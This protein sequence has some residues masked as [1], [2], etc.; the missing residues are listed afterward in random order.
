MQFKWGKWRGHRKIIYGSMR[1]KG[2][3][4]RI[5]ITYFIKSDHKN[6]SRP[7]PGDPNPCQN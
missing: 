2:P 4:P 1:V 3:R 6:G 5:Q 7:D